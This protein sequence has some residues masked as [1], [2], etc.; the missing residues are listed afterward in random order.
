MKIKL[1]K[2][3]ILMLFFVFLG[4]CGYQ[5]LLTEKY[6]K[7]TINNFEISGDR[8]LGQKLSNKFIKSEGAP[9]LL[10]FKIQMVKNR[11]QSN[12]T[13]SGKVLEYT[14]NINLNFEAISKSDSQTVLKKIYTEKVSYKASTLY[15]GTLS[16][17]KKIVD[18]LIKSIA[19]QI[20]K[21]LNLVFRS[22]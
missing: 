9:N 4:N 13:Q 8:K 14:L 16:R 6:Q 1:F 11:T 3:T 7:F 19:N 12:K 18:D 21:D 20:I 22:Q 17:E 10:V 5:P 2:I 15:S